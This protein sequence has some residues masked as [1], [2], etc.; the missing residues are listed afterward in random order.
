M[1]HYTYH[2]TGPIFRLPCAYGSFVWTRTPLSLVD[3]QRAGVHGTC[4]AAI[5]TVI[6]VHL[7]LPSLRA[8]LPLPLY[9]LSFLLPPSNSMRGGATIGSSSTNWGNR[10]S[11]QLPLVKCP[12]CCI[13][14]AG[15]RSQQRDTL[16][17]IFKCPNNIKVSEFVL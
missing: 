10:S 11:H 9:H 4:L 6:S 2:A 3:K 5:T 17:Q 14:L 13:P 8:H 7:T 16:G 1:P 15:I 12:K